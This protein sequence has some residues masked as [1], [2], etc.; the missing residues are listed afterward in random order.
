M[1]IQQKKPTS[2]SM[3]MTD[4]FI[5]SESEDIKSKERYRAVAYWKS[6]AKD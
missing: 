1:K 4:F 2:E 3:D 5:K 6:R